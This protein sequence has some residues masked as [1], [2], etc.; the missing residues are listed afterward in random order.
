MKSSMAMCGVALVLVVAGVS[1]SAESARAASPRFDATGSVHCAVTGKARF[2]PGITNAP[3]APVGWSFNGV[4]SCS[5]GTTGN[6][7]VTVTRGKLKAASSPRTGICSAVPLFAVTANITWTAKGGRVNPTHIGWWGGITSTTGSRITADLPGAAGAVTGSYAGNVGFVHL[8]GDLASFAPC[9]TAPGLK[10][11]LVSG[12]S[13]LDLTRTSALAPGGVQP[14]GQTGGFTL[15]WSDEFNG[16]ALDLSKWRPNWLGSSNT[17]TTP[18]VNSSELSCYAPGQVGV[19]D[20]VAVLTLASNSDPSCKLRSGA[21]ASYRSGLLESNGR[22]NGYTAGTYLEARV[23][24]PPGSGTPTAWPAVWTDGQSWPNDGEIDIMEVLSGGTTRWHVHDASGGPGGGPSQ[25]GGWH[26]YAAWRKAGSVT[27][28]W[29]GANVG[30][31]G[32]VT[33]AP[34]Y[35]ILN[36]AIG[37]GSAPPSLPSAFLIDYV[38]A[39]TA[40]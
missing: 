5:S 23:W 34:H 18:P 12:A 21:T 2:K 3:G 32:I 30:S 35:V 31:A 14:V 16:S 40:S 6:P 8:V 22:F 38:R 20:G 19:G 33:N 17:V 24:L 36:H 37:G 13:T 9:S 25:P 29:D 26:V 7:S 4:L 39:W 28:Y 27:F 1:V 10:G 15:K 11:Y